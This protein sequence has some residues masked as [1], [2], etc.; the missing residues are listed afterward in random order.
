MSTNNEIPLEE[1]I[2][3]LRRR[4]DV[5]ENDIERIMKDC[6]NSESF[7][8]RVESNLLLKQL[9]TNF[10]RHTEEEMVK[11]ESI[12]NRLDTIYKFGYMAVGIMVAVQFFGIT[13]KIAKLLA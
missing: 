9:T 3:E 1:V 12:D 13:D 7:T 5:L 2:I 10:Q 8:L 4:A 6:C 11:W